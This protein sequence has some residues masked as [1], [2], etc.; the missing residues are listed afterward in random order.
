MERDLPVIFQF[1]LEKGLGWDPG[2]LT[3]EEEGHGAQLGVQPPG[4]MRPKN[5]FGR[6]ML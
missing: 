5:H 6:V 3:A 4:I 1:G 2:S